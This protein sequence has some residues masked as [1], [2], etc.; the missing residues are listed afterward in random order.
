M[1][2]VMQYIVEMEMLR[3]AASVKVKKTVR[4]PRGGKTKGTRS[5]RRNH[6]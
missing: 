5:G 4:R 6:R 1:M 3:L 2:I